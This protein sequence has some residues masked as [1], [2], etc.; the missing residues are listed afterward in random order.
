MTKNVGDLDKLI[1]A[2]G[3]KQLPKKSPNLVTLI[4]V[5]TQFASWL[6][7]KTEVD[8]SHST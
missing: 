3:F 7:L 1:F 8:G 2:K 4:V 6:L 5:V